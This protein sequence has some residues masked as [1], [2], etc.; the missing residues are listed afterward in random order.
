ML[1]DESVIILNATVNQD[2]YEKLGKNPD[3]GVQ[4]KI[5]DMISEANYPDLLLDII[6]LLNNTYESDKKK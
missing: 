4:I 6:D 1:K 2:I 5:K 3:N